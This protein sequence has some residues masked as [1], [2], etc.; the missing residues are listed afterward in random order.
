MIYER[1]RLM[2]D[3]LADDGSIYV[4]CDYRVSSYLRLILDEIFGAENLINELIWCR[5]SSSAR[6][7][8]GTSE[9]KAATFIKAHDTIFLYAKDKTKFH[10]ID[11]NSHT[12]IPYSDRVLNSIETDTEGNTVYKRGKGSIGGRAISE[13]VNVD[14][15]AGMLARSYWT[16]IPILRHNSKDNVDYPTQKPEKLLERIITGTTG[17]GD[18]VADFFCGSG[19]TLAVAEKLGRK[20]IGTDLGRFA[21]HTSRKRLISVQREAS[22]FGKPFRAFE[23]FKFGWIRTGSPGW[24]RPN[25]G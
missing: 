19:T 22:K 3:L 20:W 18:L 10:G 7:S 25:S 16:D 9:N 2:K 24:V 1:L 5:T 12:S 6:N 23:I 8:S 21:I 15:G 11:K 17:V 14:V 4:H 13:T